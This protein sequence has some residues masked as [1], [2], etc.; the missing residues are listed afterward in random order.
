MKPS[1]YNFILYK[2]GK[3]YWYNGFSHLYFQLSEALGR[4]V[5][6]TISS[7]PE[8]LR[9]ISENLYDKLFQGCFIVDDNVDEVKRVIEQNENA[10][11]NKGYLLTILP[12]LNC[13]FRCWYCIQEHVAG[14]KMDPETIRKVKRHIQTKMENSDLQFLSIEWFGGEPFMYFDVIRDISDFAKDLCQK[15]RIPFISTATTNGYFLT[16]D[17]IPLL[18]EYNFNR[19]QITLDGVKSAHDKVKFQS[20]CESAFEYVL[21]NINTMLG[22]MSELNILLRVNYTRENLDEVMVE[23]VCDFIAPENRSRVTVMPRKVWQV[24]AGNTF[25]DTTGHI[26]HKFKEAGFRIDNSNI[27]KD[28]VPCYTCRRHF[29]T[30]NHNGQVL[31]CTANDDLYATDPPGYLD[32]NGQVIMKKE[33]ELKYSLKSFDNDNCRCCKYLPMCMGQCPAHYNPEKHEC[34]RASLDL[35]FEESI[36]NEIENSL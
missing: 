21:T 4:K 8:S 22:E 30:I 19:F 3:S 25:Q 2:K 31:R 28:F 7:Q 20:G 36:I 5:E 14:T 27:I 9:K 26:W 13:N 11:N 10:V 16:E 1:K 33:Y 34:K 24:T 23:Q 6:E 18:K 32:D 35:S 15:K 29:L 17:K 12:T